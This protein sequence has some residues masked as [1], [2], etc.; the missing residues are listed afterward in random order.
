MF[1][2]YDAVVLRKTLP[3]TSVPVG[4]VGTVVLIHDA[5]GQAYEAEF[6]MVT[7]RPSMCAPWLATNTW[8]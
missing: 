1:K 5:E 8:N 7:T 4:A 6:L 3:G 2:D